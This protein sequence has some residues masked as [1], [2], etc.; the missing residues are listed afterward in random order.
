MICL[1]STFLDF[2]KFLLA[3]KLKNRF[4]IEILVPIGQAVDSFLIIS[5]PS[6]S[7][8]VPTSSFFVLVLSS[9]CP[10]AAILESA[11]PL[12]P[13]DEMLNKSSAVFI[14]DVACFLKHRIA[15][16]LFIPDPLSIT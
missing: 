2:K 13:F 15:S 9:I 8:Y 11:S 10:T 1:V 14:F 5:E 6:I 4:F 12:N 7:I 16:S 3:G